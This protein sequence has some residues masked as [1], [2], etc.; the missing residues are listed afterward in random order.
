MTQASTLPRPL[1]R[2]I[3][4]P[5]AGENAGAGAHSGLRAVLGA[6][7]W[8]RLPEAVRERFAENAAAVTYAGAFEIVRASLLGRLFAWLGVIFGGPVTPRIGND[9]EAR[10]FVRPNGSGVEWIRE[11]LWAD[12]RR[13]VVRSTKVISGDARL[14]EKLPARLCMPLATWQENGVLHFES[15]GYYFD[16][17]FGFKLWLPGFFTPGITH[18]EH[19]DLGHGWFRFTMTVTHAVFGEMFF[20]TGRFCAAE[21]LE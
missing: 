17:L 10:V 13:N 6:E 7:Q 9:V 15:R 14:I 4:R 8:M 16:T 3:G 18:V 21:G 19:I 1:D 11:Y 20:Q 2:A 5:L 12:G